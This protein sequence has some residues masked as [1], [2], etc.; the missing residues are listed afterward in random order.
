MKEISGLDKLL[1]T[2]GETGANFLSW[3]YAAIA[4]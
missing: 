4:V 2:L 3:F 1:Q